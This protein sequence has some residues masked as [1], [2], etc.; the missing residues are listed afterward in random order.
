MNEFSTENVYKVMPSKSSKFGDIIILC[1]G[2]ITIQVFVF[3]CI[4]V[5]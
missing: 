1:H 3:T 2:V 4:L 5:K